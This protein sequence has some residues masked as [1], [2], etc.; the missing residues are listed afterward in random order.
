MNLRWMIRKDIPEVLDIER[1]SFEFPWKENDFIFTLQCP[2][3]VGMV[4]E[5]DDG[6]VVGFALYETKIGKTALINLA[7][8][9]EETG[10]GY[11]KVL[12]EEVKKSSDKVL[13]WIRESNLKAQ[14]WLKSQGFL[15]KKILN[16][17]YDDCGEDA[18][19]FIFTKKKDLIELKQEVLSEI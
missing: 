14:L 12:L 19:K 18:Y 17:F 8:H 11:G 7:V 16:R 13:M 5:N 4:V 6:R 10:L 15:A 1:R 9:P 2:N 3:C